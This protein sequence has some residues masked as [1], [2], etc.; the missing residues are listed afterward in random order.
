VVQ[1]SAKIKITTAKQGLKKTEMNTRT[2]DFL[3]EAP[4]QAL[5][6]IPIYQQINLHP[7][8]GRLLQ[9]LQHHATRCII[10]ID[11]N[12]QVYMLP[13][14]MNAT[15]QFPKKLLATTYQAGVVIGNEVC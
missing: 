13:C 8:L 3:N 2:A 9:S 10:V 15:N 1:P 11:V 4:R 14:G 7:T 5:R 6:S 12:L